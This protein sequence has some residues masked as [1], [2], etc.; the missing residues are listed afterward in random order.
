MKRLFYL[1]VSIGFLGCS[2][3]QK[4]IQQIHPNEWTGYIIH[5]AKLD[6]D[7]Q[8]AGNFNQIWSPIY[9][10]GAKPYHK[11]LNQPFEILGTYLSDDSEYLVIENEKGDRF[12]MAFEFDDNYYASLPSYLI[13]DNHVQKVKPLIGD[14]LWLNYTHD[15]N[16]FYTYQTYSFKRFEPVVVVEL[17]LFQNQENETP[18]WLKV[19][20]DNGLHAF[21]RYN[22]ETQKLFGEQN[23][24]FTENPL[25][26]SWGKERIQQIKRKEIVTGMTLAQV[27]LA[28]GNPDEI[29]T[30]SSR[31]SIGEQW[32]Y[33]KTL[34]QK[35]YFL[36]ENGRLVQ[37]W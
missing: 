1:L 16:Y 22:G 7:Y 21:V 34:K 6:K 10:S 23:Y 17:E 3:F 37:K 18:I 29:H 19:K 24:Y 33:G 12:K 4:P 8:L 31:T 15:Y 14:T 25:P 35:K 28:L 20:A 27:R 11:F 2:Y 5:F 13:F 36:F 26:M 32:V 30:T 9:K